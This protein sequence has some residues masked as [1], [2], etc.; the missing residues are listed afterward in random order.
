VSTVST[1][2]IFVNEQGPF[3]GTLNIETERI[4]ITMAG[5]SYKPDPEWTYVDK[6]GHFHAFTEDGK[7]PTLERYEKHLNCDGSC[8]GVCSDEGYT[9]TRYRCRACGK[10]VK[11][12]Y[13]VKVPGGA[14]QF[15]P[16]RTSWTVTVSGRT[17][18]NADVSV[19]AV[20]GGKEWF[21][22]AHPRMVSADVHDGFTYDFIGLAELGRR[23]ITERRAAA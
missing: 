14:Q 2:E 19:R 17:Q 15:M 6:A 10:R 3:V 22:L 20:A 16:G 13:A 21:G 11:P 4:D 7:L 9:E 12:G 5:P 18:W 1:L 8:A 23:V